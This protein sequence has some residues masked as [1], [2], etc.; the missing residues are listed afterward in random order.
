MRAYRRKRDSIY[1]FLP[2]VMY[3]SLRHLFRIEH[4][5]R[6]EAI[7][8]NAVLSEYASNLGKYAWDRCSPF[9]TVITQDARESRAHRI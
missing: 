5:E 4:F 2:T 1:A 7:Q 3:V 8:L 6:L 9:K